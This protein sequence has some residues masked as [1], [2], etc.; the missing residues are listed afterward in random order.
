LI[1]PVISKKDETQDYNFYSKRKE[2]IR[3]NKTVWNALQQAMEELANENI[4]NKKILDVLTAIEKN[5]QR[6]EIFNRVEKIL[7]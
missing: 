1:K 4:Q 2:V 6:A 5:M 3:K 7:K